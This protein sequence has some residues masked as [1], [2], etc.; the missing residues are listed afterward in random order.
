MEHIGTNK[1]KLIP[2]IYSS[3]EVIFKVFT[4]SD[5]LCCNDHSCVQAGQFSQHRD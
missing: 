4:V 1:V 2:N 5:T 3:H